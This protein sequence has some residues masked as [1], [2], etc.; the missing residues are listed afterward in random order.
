MSADHGPVALVTGANRGLGLE[1]CRQLT[2]AGYRVVLSARDV[3]K[4]REAAAG[5]G[6][7]PLGLDVTDQASIDRAVAEVREQ[8]GRVDTLVNNAGVLIDGFDGRVAKQTIDVNFSGP[9][10]VTD[11]FLPMLSPDA[12][13][14]MVSSGLG[15]LSCLSADRRKDFADPALT[16]PRLIDLIGEFVGDVERGVWS[17]RGWP[18]S[19]Y[20]VSKAGLNALTRILA[21]EL[22][23]TG[24]RVNAVCPGWVRT[25]MGGPNAARDVATGARSIVWAATLGPDGPS[26]GF[27]RDGVEIPW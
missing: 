16:R 14:V 3:G 22:A 10:R 5:L 2:A 12:S 13:I 25:D 11:A 21:R 27:F 6:A 7:V 9:M 4:A 18:K 8:L 17:R 23:G 20:S 15:E 19:A 26:G 24:I 1:T